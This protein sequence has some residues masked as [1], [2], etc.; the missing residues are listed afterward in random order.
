MPDPPACLNCR[1]PVMPG[2]GAAWWHLDTM[3]AWCGFVYGKAD[4]AMPYPIPDDRRAIPDREFDFG[5]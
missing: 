1:A 3:H 2:P 4:Q 5:E